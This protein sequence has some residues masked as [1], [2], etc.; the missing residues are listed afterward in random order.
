MQINPF[1]AALALG[2]FALFSLASVANAQTYTFFP[3]DAT[4]NTVVNTNYAIVGYASG[5]NGNFQTPSSPTVNIVTG[6]GISGDVFAYNSSIINMSGGNVNGYL[7]ARNNSVINMSGGNVGITLVTYN[8]SIGNY[9]G[10]NVTLSLEADHASTINIFGSNLTAT[11]AD[12]NYFGFSF[13]NLSGTLQDGTVL[14]NKPLLTQN[15][16]GASFHLNPT[17]VPAPGSLLVALGGIFPGI[18][19]LRQRRK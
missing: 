7:A 11:L 2:A 5:T 16:T 18:L 9:R 10:G 14:S 8:N 1:R 19:L 3:N 12:P 6:S 4:I 15:G 13:Y 17:A